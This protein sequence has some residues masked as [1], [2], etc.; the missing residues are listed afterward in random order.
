[1]SRCCPRCPRVSLVVL[2][3]ALAVLLPT[4]L[5][6][7]MGMGG[8]GGAGPGPP[9]DRVDTLAFAKNGT[10]LAG[11]GE[12]KIRIWTREP[13][14][15]VRTMT[16]EP[17]IR[18]IAAA[19][20]GTLLAVNCSDRLAL[21]DIE[22]GVVFKTLFTGGAVGTD[23]NHVAFSPDG[24]LLASVHNQRD[25]DGDM[26]KAA[27]TIRLWDVDRGV[28]TTAF[29]QEPGT[30]AYALAFAPDGTSFVVGIVHSSGQRLQWTE[31]RL[32]RIDRSLLDWTVGRTQT[33]VRELAYSPDGQL[34]AA[35]GWRYT[36]G[37]RAESVAE[38]SLWNVSTGKRLWW[39]E[40]SLQGA[41][42]FSPEGLS[43]AGI[44]RTNARSEIVIRDVA[45]SRTRTLGDLDADPH[46]RCQI[47]YSP[48]GTV[49]AACSG[50]RLVLLDTET[51][52]V[53]ET[54]WPLPPDAD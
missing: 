18:C 37:I 30:H 12:N 13:C 41:P 46:G 19:P 15:L 26:T 50:Q 52:A 35:A 21:W 8:M 11:A 34:L 44:S 4:C 25:P 31:I 49:L 14:K 3:L 32:V 20:R 27:A 16:T 24:K 28:E 10:L 22:A 39:V 2:L 40:N 5:F 45:T 48:D 53:R 43:I 51:L 23:T 29:A 36:L 17:W 33:A 38:L 9:L 6:A 42:E 54:L 7:Q 1:M 47:A